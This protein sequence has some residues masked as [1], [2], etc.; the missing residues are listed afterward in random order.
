M[1]TRCTA[2]RFAGKP[3]GRPPKSIPE[4]KDELKRLKAQRR[5]GYREYIPIKRKL[6]QGKNDCR[7]NKILAMRADISVA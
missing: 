2:I 5:Q 4:N 7:L 1:I 6:C 3:L